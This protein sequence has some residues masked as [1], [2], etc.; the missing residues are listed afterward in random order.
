MSR[1]N[2]NTSTREKVITRNGVTSVN[3]NNIGRSGLESGL[4]RRKYSLPTIQTVG[5]SIKAK[6]PGPQGPQVQTVWPK[7]LDSE[8]M[9]IDQGELWLG[10]V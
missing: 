1:N 4:G 10:L 5:H 8:A 6:T 9:D 3:N 7:Y 2:D